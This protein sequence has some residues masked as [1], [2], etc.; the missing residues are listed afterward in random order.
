MIASNWALGLC[1]NPNQAL[2]FVEFANSVEG[3]LVMALKGLSAT[4]DKSTILGH[5]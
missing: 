4:V 2:G 3:T 5:C 1:Q